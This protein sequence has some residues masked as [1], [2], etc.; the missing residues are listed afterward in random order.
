MINVKASMKAHTYYGSPDIDFYHSFAGA[1]G[2]IIVRV[3][4]DD[5]IYM[6]RIPN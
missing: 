5:K 4:I 6:G 3:Y 1:K 2:N